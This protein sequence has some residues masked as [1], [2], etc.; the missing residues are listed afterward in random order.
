MLPNLSA[1]QS[2]YIRCG[3]NIDSYKHG[4]F[5]DLHAAASLSPV[6]GIAWRPPI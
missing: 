4:L 5:L 6:T 2:D 3:A 1:I